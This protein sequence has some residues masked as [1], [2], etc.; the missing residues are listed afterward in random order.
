MT[1]R[2]SFALGLSSSECP[3]LLTV[4]TGYLILYRYNYC[5]AENESSYVLSEFT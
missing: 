5:S 4:P 2:H 3:A 1:D